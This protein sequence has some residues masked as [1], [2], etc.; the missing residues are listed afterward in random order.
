MFRRSFDD[1]LRDGAPVSPCCFILAHLT[2]IYSK[3]ISVIF[4]ITCVS[5]EIYFINFHGIQQ[6]LFTYKKETDICYEKNFLSSWFCID[7]TNTTS[8]NHRVAIQEKVWLIF[9]KIHQIMFN[10]SI[11]VQKGCLY[12]SHYDGFKPADIHICKKVFFL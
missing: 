12:R 5:E 9:F 10:V 4:M 7:Y 11:R 3:L 6:N 8:T 1:V 2:V